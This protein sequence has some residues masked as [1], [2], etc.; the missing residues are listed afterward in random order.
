MGCKCTQFDRNGNISVGCEVDRR[1]KCTITIIAS[2][3]VTTGEYGLG[4]VRVGC[5]VAHRRTGAPLVSERERTCENLAILCSVS[6]GHWSSVPGG[7][8][9]WKRVRRE[10]EENVKR[11]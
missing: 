9:E 2:T 3:S 5:E 1:L 10:C 7:G 6:S 8:R 4:Y 11:M